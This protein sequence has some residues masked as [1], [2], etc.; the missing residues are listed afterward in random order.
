M[1]AVPVLG[2]GI[3]ANDEF[4]G[5]ITPPYQKRNSAGENGMQLNF[6]ILPAV[7]HCVPI[8]QARR[9]STSAP[10]RAA[11]ED[12]PSTFSLRNSAI[13]AFSASLST[14]VFSAALR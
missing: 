4:L 12:S 2:R 1:A 14:R 13:S 10:A 6:T 7:E 5:D 9:C 11:G 8:D 3:A